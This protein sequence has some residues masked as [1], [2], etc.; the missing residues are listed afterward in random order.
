MR[1]GRGQNKPSPYTNSQMTPTT[2]RWGPIGWRSAMVPASGMRAFMRFEAGVPSLMHLEI[3]L[4]DCAV[5]AAL[6]RAPQQHLSAADRL[7]LHFHLLRSCQPLRLFSRGPSGTAV[8]IVPKVQ[9]TG[10]CCR[11]WWATPESHPHSGNIRI[12]II[13]RLFQGGTS[14]EAVATNARRLNDPLIAGARHR[15]LRFVVR[16]HGGTSQDNWHA[17]DFL[18]HCVGK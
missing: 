13:F 5:V 11:R 12:R 10:C 17:A 1:P 2:T 4:V 9:I 6:K 7:T 3:A 16:V 14:V 8:S 18:S 15:V